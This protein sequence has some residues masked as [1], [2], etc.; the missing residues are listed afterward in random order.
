MPGCKR[1]R[2][3]PRR[4]ANTP[5][6]GSLVSRLGIVETDHLRSEPGLLPLVHLVARVG[7]RLSPTGRRG[8]HSRGQ[9]RETGREA[10]GMPLSGPPATP[11]R[12]Y[13]H[14]ESEPRNPTHQRPTVTEKQRGDGQVPTGT[15]WLCASDTREQATR[16]ALRQDRPR[17]GQGEK[18]P[19]GPTKQLHYKQLHPSTPAFLTLVNMVTPLPQVCV[20]P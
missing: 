18:S 13:R 15:F 6:R 9:S 11:L 4:A 19:Q 10:M 2:Y 12:E 20:Q 8:Q 1:A 5:R 16:I 17:Q 14:Y 3:E 7:E